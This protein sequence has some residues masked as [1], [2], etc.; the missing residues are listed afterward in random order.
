MRGQ[1]H[2]H[3]TTFSRRKRT[4][5]IPP[6]SFKSLLKEVLLDTSMIIIAPRRESALGEIASLPKMRIP[7]PPDI[8]ELVCEGTLLTYQGEESGFPDPDLTKNL[9]NDLL[10]MGS[11]R[12]EGRLVSRGRDSKLLNGDGE[13]L[14][15]GIQG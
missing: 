5:G 15:E 9:L 12:E 1:S 4:K 2:N 11:H 14:I 3:I 7:A 13:P 8:D 10:I 6:G